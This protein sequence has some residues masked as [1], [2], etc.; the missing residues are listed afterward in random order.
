[1]NYASTPNHYLGKPNFK[2]SSI[3]LVEYFM[4]I[5]EFIWV[6][7]AFD[8]YRP[9]IK[10]RLEGMLEQVKS[11]YHNELPLEKQ[12]WILILLVLRDL[13]THS[14]FSYS[15]H[16]INYVFHHLEE[17]SVEEL[18]DYANTINDSF[19]TEI[20]DYLSVRPLE[21]RTMQ[22]D[23]YNQDIQMQFFLNKKETLLSI[24]QSFVEEKDIDKSYISKYASNPKEITQKY[25]T[26]WNLF[27]EIYTG[28]SLSVYDVQQEASPMKEKELEEILRQTNQV[29]LTSVLHKQKVIDALNEKLIQ[30]LKPL[31]L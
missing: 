3:D 31:Y 18:E 26:F 25:T 20:M 9:H 7:E 30:E 17:I 4:Y 13:A 24:F 22:S 29:F 10:E 8:S 11:Q 27:F 2:E 12:W 15:V 21:M 19:S 14:Q 23:V 5:F 16:A 1:M 28:F 6:S